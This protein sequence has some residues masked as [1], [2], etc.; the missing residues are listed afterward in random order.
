MFLLPL[1]VLFN[2]CVT[3]S[4]IASDI[5]AQHRE[6]EIGKKTNLNGSRIF[7][8]LGKREGLAVLDGTVFYYAISSDF[9]PLYDNEHLTGWGVMIDTYCYETVPDEYGRTKIKYVPYVIPLKD[10]KK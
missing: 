5:E 6:F 4:L 9:D 10:Y 2:S 3:L 1:F 8:T 7:Q